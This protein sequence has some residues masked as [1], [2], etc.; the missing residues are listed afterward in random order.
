[1]KL[2]LD[3]GRAIDVDE[4]LVALAVS[5]LGVG[6]GAQRVGVHWVDQAVFLSM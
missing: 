4:A 1:M 6:S 2:R 5:A 3:G